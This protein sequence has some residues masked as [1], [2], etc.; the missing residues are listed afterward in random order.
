[1]DAMLQTDEVLLTSRI[2]QNG[3]ELLVEVKEMNRKIDKV[4]GQ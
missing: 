1:M 3:N 4:G 2:C